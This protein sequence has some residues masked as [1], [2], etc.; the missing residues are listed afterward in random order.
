MNVP[1]SSLTAVPA[2]R[3][4]APQRT[5]AV[6]TIESTAAAWSVLLLP[7]PYTRTVPLH[8]RAAIQPAP[9]SL[10]VVELHGAAAWPALEQEIRV[11]RQRFPCCPIA[12]QID[13]GIDDLYYVIVRASRLPVRA[14]LLRGAA[15]P[16]LLRRH[17]A[18]PPALADDVVEWLQLRGIRMSPALAYLVW[19]IFAR[20]PHHSELAT[21][22]REIGVVESSARFRFHKKSLPP[23]SRW[24]QMAR[25]LYAALRIQAEP[26]KPLLRLAL[27]LGYSDHSALSHQ[28]HRTFRLRASAIRQLLGWEW[29]L[30]RWL[31]GARKS[32]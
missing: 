21:L 32:A 25:A 5:A 26:D 24:L 27:E 2:L 29:L 3:S 22:C 1:S 17:L 11:L 28:I 14:V 18:Q 8:G 30:D 10:L 4:V 9:A 19:Q 15:S 12:L 6:L 16:S 20:A 7:P 23:P 31:Q 13:P